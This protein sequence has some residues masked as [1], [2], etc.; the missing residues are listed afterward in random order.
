[1]RLLHAA[2]H[3]SVY[4]SVK[5]LPGLMDAAMRTIKHYGSHSG[6]RPKNI[7]V[8]RFLS[9]AIFPW[10]CGCAYASKTMT[11]RLIDQCPHNCVFLLAEPEWVGVYATKM[12]SDGARELPQW[13]MGVINPQGVAKVEVR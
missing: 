8:N 13:A 11:L 9:E 6:F 12:T 10:Y 7:I 5:R 2:A 1:M 4:G 3:T